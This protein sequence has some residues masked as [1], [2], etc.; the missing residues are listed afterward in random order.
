MRKEAGFNVMDHINITIEGNK[1]ICAIATKCSADISGD[2]LADRLIA[3][4][5]L[6]YVKEWDINGEKV[7]IGV[8]KI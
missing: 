2:T 1:S 8:E 7:T 5:A 4:T 3:A 6:G